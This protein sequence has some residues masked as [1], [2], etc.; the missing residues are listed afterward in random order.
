VA[1]QSPLLPLVLNARRDPAFRPPAPADPRPIAFHR[2]LPAYVPTPLVHLDAVA[3]DL[4]LGC[5]VVKN[6]QRRLGLPAYKV[7]GGAWVV[8]QVIARRAGLPPDRVVAFDELARLARTLGPVTLCTATDG[9]H[10]RGIAAMAQALGFSSAVYVPADIAPE[11]LAAIAGHGADVRR[12]AGSY[13]DVVD[14]ARQ[15]SAEHGYWL[16]ADTAQGGEDAFPTWV[17]EGYTT[18]FDELDEQLSAT[19]DALFLQ[20]GVGA[21]AAAGVAWLRRRSAEARAV[22][23]EPLGSNCVQA[24]IAAGRPTRVDD[25]FT[26][27]AGLRAQR[28]S[29]TA[30]PTLVRGLDAAVAIGDAET[31]A[32]MRLLARAGVEA[33]GSGAAGLAGL[34]AVA[35]DPESR[36]ALGLG[37]ATRVLTLN[38]EGATDSASYAAIVGAPD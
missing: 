34:L 38:T 24:S 11:R 4:G 23:V 20:A 1:C 6:D 36:A 15:A 10:G 8:H 26:I 33:G 29:E 35:T 18:L 31:R 7:L 28:V 12:V 25:A 16:C 21:L 3:R 5:V 13:D 27:M 22:T 14:E 9:N 19:P 2:T 32:A 17:Q 30:W 37:P